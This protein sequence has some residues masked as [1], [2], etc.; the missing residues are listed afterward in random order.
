MRP[1][2]QPPT[3][4]NWPPFSAANLPPALIDELE[5]ILE[6]LYLATRELDRTVYRYEMLAALGRD[7]AFVNKIN[8]TSAAPGLTT[9]NGCIF[10]AVVVSLCAFFDD[11]PGAVNLRMILNRVVRPEYLDRFREFHTLTNPTFDTDWQ[12]ERL[13]RLQRRLNRGDT[14]KA[15]ARLNDLRNQIVA[16]LDTQPQFDD[17]WPVNAD[18]AIVL[19]AVA[20]TVISLVRFTIAE[21]GVKPHEGRRNAQRQARALCAAIRPSVIGRRADLGYRVFFST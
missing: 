11:T 4:I 14:G 8:G 15:L 6:P 13:L 2:F 18:M 20:N 12:R 10:T 1:Q 9:I 19:A 21:R 17:G 3:P 7:W 5:C 16:H